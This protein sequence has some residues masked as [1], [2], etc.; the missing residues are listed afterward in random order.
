MNVRV[1]TGYHEASRARRSISWTGNDRSP[2][3]A[4][5]LLLFRRV[6]GGPGSSE[7]GWPDPG[8]LRAAGHHSGRGRGWDAPV[9]GDVPGGRSKVSDSARRRDA[10]ARLDHVHVSRV[11]E[12]G[13]GRAVQR[14]SADAHPVR[15]V[16]R[17]SIS[18]LRVHQ[19]AVRLL[20][21]EVVG[22][23]S[24]NVTGRSAERV[25]LQLGG[26]SSL[27][28]RSNTPNF[29]RVFKVCLKSIGTGNRMLPTR[30]FQTVREKSSPI[31]I[32][33]NIIIN[34]VIFFL[35]IYIPALNCV[36][37]ER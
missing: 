14:P 23:I 6:W 5:L 16:V 31:S 34:I 10:H 36:A 11:P 22:V 13:R 28:R 2:G 29:E 7:T 37:W 9:D 35:Y 21:S 15:P 17:R 18:R 8:R 27:T 3:N 30:P 24:N 1:F 32:L 4:Q 33:V 19:K 12:R 20:G 26:M 25:G